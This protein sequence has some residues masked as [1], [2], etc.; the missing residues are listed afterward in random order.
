VTGVSRDGVQP[1]EFGL[2]QNFPNPFNPTTSITFGVARRS[3]LRLVVYDLLGR[4]L[5][6]LADGVYEAG[7]YSAKADFTGRASGVYF[8][9]LEAGSFQQVRKLVV[10]R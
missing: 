3:A 9:R 8:Y 10:A 2:A 7:T 6:T 5:M 4:K 1:S